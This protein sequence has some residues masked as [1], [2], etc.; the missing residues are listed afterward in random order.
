MKN[1]TIRKIEEKDFGALIIL[2]KEFA[3]FEKLPEKMINTEQQMQI[4][5]DYVNGFVA[6]SESNKIVGFVTFFFAYYTWTGKSIFMD[7]LYVKSNFRG[8]GIGSKLMKSVIEY[9]KLE[10]CNKLRWQVSKWNKDAID[11][12]ENL[13]ATI[14]TIEINCDLSLK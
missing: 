9:A 13:G 5:K 10:S 2:F 11:F 4:E 8:N 7:D 14:D 6:L 12:Y 3:K 1:I